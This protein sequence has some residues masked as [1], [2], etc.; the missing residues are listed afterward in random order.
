MTRSY[1]G[2]SAPRLAD[3]GGVTWMLAQA[4]ATALFTRICGPRTPSP[5]ATFLRRRNFWRGRVEAAERNERIAT[6]DA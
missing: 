3:F 4:R 6:R 2:T 1:D 5:R